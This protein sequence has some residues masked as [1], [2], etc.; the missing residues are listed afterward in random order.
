MTV[1]DLLAIQRD[2]VNRDINGAVVEEMCSNMRITEITV[3]VFYNV[4]ALYMYSHRALPLLN[5]ACVEYDLSEICHFLEHLK[6]LSL[7]I[8]C[9]TMTW[10]ARITS[11][12]PPQCSTAHVHLRLN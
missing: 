9:N 7:Q 4:S 11:D 8:L 3:R 12:T 5:C 10:T 1:P 2:S 6:F